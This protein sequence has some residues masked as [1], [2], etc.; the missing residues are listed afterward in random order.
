L[1]GFQSQ[2]IGIMTDLANQAQQNGQR[3]LGNI[4][5]KFIWVKL[6][7]QQQLLTGMGNF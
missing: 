3:P 2:L 6:P 4:L 5:P 7:S 1:I